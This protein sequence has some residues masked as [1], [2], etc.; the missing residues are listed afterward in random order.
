MAA[1]FKLNSTLLIGL[2]LLSDEVR[3]VFDFV[4][5]ATTKLDMWSL[6]CQEIFCIID[7]KCQYTAHCQ[8][9]ISWWLAAIS[10]IA[11]LLVCVYYDK[12]RDLK[13][14]VQVE[15]KRADKLQEKLQELLSDSVK[16]RQCK[17]RMRQIFGLQ[18]SVHRRSLFFTAH[19]LLPIFMFWVIS[20]KPNLPCC[21]YSDKT[22]LQRS[23]LSSRHI[24][25]WISFMKIWWSITSVTEVEFPLGQCVFI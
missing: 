6:F 15:R 11:D 1:S 13:K 10:A 14:Q 19:S 18:I 9:Y 7:M 24:Q 5:Q 4:A 8:S 20:Y 17:K 12:M 25:L 22:V 3:Q 2:C 23:L 16:R 21:Q